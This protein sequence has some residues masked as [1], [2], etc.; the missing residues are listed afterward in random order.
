ML[1]P[2][3]S[4]RLVLKLAKS[5]YINKQATDE[6]SIVCNRRLLKGIIGVYLTVNTIIPASIQIFEAAVAIEAPFMLNF[7]IRR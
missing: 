2:T 3:T 6:T 4:I 5:K 1:N 7:G